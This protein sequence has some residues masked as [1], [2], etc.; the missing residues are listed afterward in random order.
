MFGE[1]DPDEVAGYVREA[2]HDL[3]PAGA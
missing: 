2:V 1:V 3:F